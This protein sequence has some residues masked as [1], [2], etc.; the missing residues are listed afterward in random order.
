MEQE[1]R[2]TE[3]SRVEKRKYVRS[4]ER[5]I[6]AAHSKAAANEMYVKHATHISIYIKRAHKLFK[7]G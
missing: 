6:P 4:N 3:A 1:G 2:S 5:K 7:E